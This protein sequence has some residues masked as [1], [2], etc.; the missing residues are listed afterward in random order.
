MYIYDRIVEDLLKCRG[1]WASHFL[2]PPPKANDSNIWLHELPVEVEPLGL[3][4][5]LLPSKS[6]H[7]V[8]SPPSK[9]TFTKQKRQMK[10]LLKFSW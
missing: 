8:T 4:C 1:R 9:T 7:L 5:F 3:S 10:S 6:W 2:F